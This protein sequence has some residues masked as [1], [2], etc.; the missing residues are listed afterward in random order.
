MPLQV[1]AMAPTSKVVYRLLH[2]LRRATP[3]PLIHTSS[4][5]SAMSISGGYSNAPQ[6][7]P[8]THRIR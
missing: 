1:K 7:D 3:P 4:A 5:G 6:T 8:A 2:N